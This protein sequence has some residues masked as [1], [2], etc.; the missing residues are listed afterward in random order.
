M[1]SESLPL[2]IHENPLMFMNKEYLTT[3]L[4]KNKY[5]SGEITEITQNE[6]PIKNIIKFKE[7]ALIKDFITEFN[8]KPISDQF[9][10]NII[11]TKVNKTKEEIKKEHEN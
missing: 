8:N 7:E 10:Y 2:I 5:S 4:L 1:N 6:V 9:N 3:N 11:L